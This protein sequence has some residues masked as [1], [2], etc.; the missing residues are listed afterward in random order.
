MHDWMLLVT[1]HVRLQEHIP[2]T[3]LTDTGRCIY[4]QNSRHLVVKDISFTAIRQCHRL[5]VE[6][7]VL[8]NPGATVVALSGMRAVKQLH[9]IAAIRIISD[10][11]ARPH[12][13]TTLLFGF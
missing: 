4:L 13:Q 12:H 6:M 2:V 5:F 1:D 7:I 11:G 10:P 9:E 3:G 8:G